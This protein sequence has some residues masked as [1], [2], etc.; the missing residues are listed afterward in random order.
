VGLAGVLAV[1][2]SRPDARL[3]VP[4]AWATESLPIQAAR[5]PRTFAAMATAATNTLEQRFYHAPGQ[6]NLCVP[7][8]CGAAFR[9]WGADALAYTLFLRWR[10][11]HDPSIEPLMRDLAQSAPEYAICKR[12]ACAQWSDV[13]MWDAIAAARAYEV[14]GN[15]A[16]LRK[17][18]RAFNAVDFTDAYALGACPTIDFQRPGGGATALK[19]LETDSNYIKAALLLERLTGQSAFLAK[20]RAKYAAARLYFLDKRVALYSVYVFD[21]GTQ[22]TQLPKRFF[23][24]VNGNMID[25]G[26]M[27]ARRTGDRSY[28]RD[29][30][31]TA[32]A[33]TRYLSDGD[34]IYANLQADNDVAEPLIEAMYD[35]AT[36]EHQA[37]A[38]RWLLAAAGAAQPA[39]SGG[40]G[41]FFGG[42][43]PT[44]SISAWSSNGGLALAIVAGALDPGG[45]TVDPDYWNLRRFVADPIAAAP[46]TISFTGRAIALI[47][48][49]GDVCCEAGHVRVFIDG[50]ETVNN[51]GIWQNKSPAARSLPNSVLL[52]WRWRRSGAHTIAF[53]PG[54]T[55]AKEGGPYLHLAGYEFVP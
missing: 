21:D 55:N 12:A 54:I 25:N 6:W 44:G 1:V 42:P 36:Q 23:A 52:S 50:Q 26:L 5:Q 11:S 51:T 40:Y 13:P 46:A 14:T 4:A 9:D 53:K 41:R 15:P 48:T 20:A 22:C 7:D 19:T 32:R 2:G 27:L 16:A 29:A 33:V 49:I 47:G 43:A 45:A 39:A 10:L 30:L 17:A 24:S 8:T 31:D 38:R 28:R 18:R 3:G 35:V 34:G 37:F